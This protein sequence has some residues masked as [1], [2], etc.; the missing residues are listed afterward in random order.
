MLSVTFSRRVHQDFLYQE[1]ETSFASARALPYSPQDTFLVNNNP[2]TT[3]GTKPWSKKL[4][5]G[6]VG[7]LA[8]STPKERNESKAVHEAR[9]VFAHQ[10]PTTVA[11]FKDR[12]DIRSS[13]L[14]PNG[15]ALVDILAVWGTRVAGWQFIRPP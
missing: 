5:A 15:S 14:L 7:A 13:D 1:A 8:K 12:P 3:T 11:Q 9:A 4:R 6:V 2:T 10:H